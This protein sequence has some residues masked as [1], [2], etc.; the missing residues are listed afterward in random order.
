MY[1]DR[2]ER[3]AAYDAQPDLYDAHCLAVYGR[4]TIP[5]LEAVA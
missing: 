2:D 3:I 1:K 5:H 4:L